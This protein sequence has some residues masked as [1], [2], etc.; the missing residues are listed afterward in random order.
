MQ[1][2]RVN[3]QTVSVDVSVDLAVQIGLIL[4]EVLTNAFQHA[5]TG[6]KRGVVDVN[7]THLKGEKLS[8]IVKDDGVGM[9]NP[10]D[11]PELGGSGSHIVRGMINFANAEVDV[12][13]DKSGTRIQISFSCEMS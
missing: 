8:V 2:I 3:T 6:R 13:S 5:F 1:G 11:W 7:V 4:S 10:Q 12:H 9:E